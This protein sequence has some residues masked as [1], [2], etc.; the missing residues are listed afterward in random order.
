MNNKKGFTL[1]ELLAIIVILAIIIAIA[2]PN[3]TKQIQKQ[4]TEEQNILNQKIENAAHL[5]A[6]KYYA[7]KI[8][9][10]NLCDEFTGI[11]A[12]ITLNDLEQDGLLRLKDSE[13]ATNGTNDRSNKSIYVK[14]VNGKIQYDY[15]QVKKLLAC[16]KC[17]R[18]DGSADSRGNYCSL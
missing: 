10:T 6:A 18:S 17:P 16:Y 2:A 15:R 7:N 8:V 3:M 11:C 9:D 13:C 14:N 4:E 1:T 12:Y 5:Y